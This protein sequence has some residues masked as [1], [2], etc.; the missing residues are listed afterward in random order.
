MNIPNL[1]FEGRKALDSLGDNLG[2]IVFIANDFQQNAV[3]IGG[4]P[5]IIIDVLADVMKTDPRIKELFEAAWCKAGEDQSI[6]LN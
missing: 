1:K 3:C 5:D 2:A 6:S 4:V